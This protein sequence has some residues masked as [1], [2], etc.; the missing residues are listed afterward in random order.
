MREQVG[1]GPTSLSPLNFL[2]PSSSKTFSCHPL[3]FTSPYPGPASDAELPIR[4]SSC[5]DPLLQ[6]PNSSSSHTLGWPHYPLPLLGNLLRVQCATHT[7]PQ[8]LIKR[9]AWATHFLLTRPHPRQTPPDMAPCRHSAS[10]FL[11][12]QTI[13]STTIWKALPSLSAKSRKYPLNKWSNISSP[14]GNLSRI[15]SLKP[16]LSVI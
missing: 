13:S 2:P 8:L 5:L 12:L 6:P 7:E 4:Q 16:C 9:V 11:L 14:P 10:Y 3:S 1:P 15:T